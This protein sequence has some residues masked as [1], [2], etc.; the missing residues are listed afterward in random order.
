M[1][2]VYHIRRPGMKSNEGYI[3]VSSRP[4]TRKKAHFSAAQQSR[5]ENSYLQNAI[6]K[7]S[8][9]EFVILHSNLSRIEAYMAEEFYRPTSKIGWN[10][11]AGGD[12]GY[13]ISDETKA[14]IGAA[15]IGN[16]NHM[17]GRTHSAEVRARISAANKLKQISEDHKLAV[18]K[19][20]S[21]KVLSDIT[22]ALLRDA[23]LYGKSA[24]ARRVLCIETNTTYN[25]LSEAA[26]V[27]GI[28]Y[29][30]ITKVCTGKHKT[31]GGYT[32]K[33]LT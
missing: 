27:I 33:Y 30:N 31:A 9:I 24:K 8:D 13:E 5:H 28:H 21:G 29:S 3:G 4:K 32:W 10:I 25:A 11:K 1:F 14:K 20:Q 2:S 23:N 15:Q 6:Q 26:D 12:I 19:A 18:S 7:Y 16:K 17:Y 22:K